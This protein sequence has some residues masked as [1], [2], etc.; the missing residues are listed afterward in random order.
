[1]AMRQHFDLSQTDVG[2]LLHEREAVAQLVCC[3]VLLRENRGSD[4]IWVLR[5]GDHCW[6]DGRAEMLWR[7]AGWSPGSLPERN[8]GGF[9]ETSCIRLHNCPVTEL[10][11][12]RDW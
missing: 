1:M 9:P 2:W 8:S 4:Q 12:T 7:D 5:L 11:R 10:P 6:C 3:G